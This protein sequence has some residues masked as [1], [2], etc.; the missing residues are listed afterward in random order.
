METFG[1]QL[2]SSVKL[3]PLPDSASSDGRETVKAFRHEVQKQW[4]PINL[5]CFQALKEIELNWELLSTG[6][7]YKNHSQIKANR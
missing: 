4:Q 6:I 7:I 2:H 5:E 3:N 1:T